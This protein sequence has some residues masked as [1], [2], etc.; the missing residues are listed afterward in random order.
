MT[1]KLACFCRVGTA[2]QYKLSSLYVAHT[3]NT[4]QNGTV[5]RTLPTCRGERPFTPTA[6]FAD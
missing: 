6:Y 4:S 1:K 2:H 5:W 3:T